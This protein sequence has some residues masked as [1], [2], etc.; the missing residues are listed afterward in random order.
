M[1]KRQIAYLLMSLLFMSLLL[2]LSACGMG[3]EAQEAPPEEE[4]PIA[5]KPVIYLYPEEETEVSVTLQF[6][7]ELLYTYPTYEDGWT[8]TAYPDGRIQKDGV[9]YSYLFWDGVSDAQYDLSKGFVVSGAQTEAFLIETLS[10]LGLNER[11]ANEFIVYW[12]P[13]MVQ[14]PY[15]L[16]TF[17]EEAYTE[18]AKLHI[19]PSPDSLQRVFM[20]FAPLDEPIEVEPQILTPFVREGFTVIEWG[21]TELAVPPLG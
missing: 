4:P 3:G 7:G 2:T 19:S 21:G 15:N 11:E 20:V 16:I 14:N 17:Q 8:V 9:Q 10:Y 18:N 12:V 13:R 6:A 5:E 1:K